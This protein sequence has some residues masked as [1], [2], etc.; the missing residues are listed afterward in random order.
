MRVIGKQGD[1]K[2]GKSRVFRELSLENLGPLDESPLGVS[3]SNP[4]IISFC[5]VLFFFFFSKEMKESEWYDS[6][7]ELWDKRGEIESLKVMRSVSDE[8]RASGNL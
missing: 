7:Y 5:F 1:D 6:G 8:E 4:G 3:T 2:D